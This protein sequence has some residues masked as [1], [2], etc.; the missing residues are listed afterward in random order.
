[1]DVLDTLGGHGGFGDGDFALFV[2]PADFP[3]LFCQ[4]VVKALDGLGVEGF[5][6]DSTQG[7]LDVYAN[8]CFVDFQRPGLDSAAVGGY[9]GVQPLPQC[10]LAGSGIGAVVNGGGGCLQLLGNFLLGF[11]GNGALHLLPGA[12]VGAL[13]IAGFPV[14]V[15]L[16][17][18]GDGF[19]S[20]RAGAVCGPPCHGEKSPFF[21]RPGMLS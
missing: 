12:G 19:L 2:L 10:L 15:F 13:R 7:G 5:R 16:P 3:A 1:M 20:D 6:A 14:F 21:L 18:S 4:L 11:A 9:P 17:V 8:I